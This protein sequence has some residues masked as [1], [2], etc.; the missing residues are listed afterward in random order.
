MKS[1]KSPAD[2]IKKRDNVQF[3]YPKIEDFHAADSLLEIGCGAGWLSN[4]IAYYYGLDV[5]GIDFNPKAIEA[6]QKR[7]RNWRLMFDLS[8]PICF[9]I[10]V[11]Q[12]IS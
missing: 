11:S 10:N 5:T 7:Q 6:D 9:N 2:L 3:I 12:K 4:S 1:R 8:V